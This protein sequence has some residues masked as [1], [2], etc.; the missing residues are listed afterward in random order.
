MTD[1]SILWFFNETAPTAIYTS[2]FVFLYEFIG[3]RFSFFAFLG[4]FNVFS[5]EFKYFGFILAAAI[6]ILIFMFLQEAFNH[7]W[8]GINLKYA[9]SKQGI[10]FDWGVFRHHELDL[11]FDQ[12]DSI[13]IVDDK[14]RNAIIFDNKEGIKNSSY[15]FGN[16]LSASVLSFENVTLSYGMQRDAIQKA[17]SHTMGPS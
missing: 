11:D 10:H 2:F 4:L 8:N 16:E 3:A 13:Y 17:Q 12:I 15:G 5:S 7:F 14:K 6:S 9:I 1:E